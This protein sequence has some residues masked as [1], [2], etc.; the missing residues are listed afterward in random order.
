VRR[1]I[2][3][4]FHVARPK[5]AD[6]KIEERVEAARHRTSK[7]GEGF[8]A[9]EKATILVV[10][11]DVEICEHFGLILGENGFTVRCAN[12]GNAALHILD[13][14]AIDVIIS[15]ILMPNGNGLKVRDRAKALCIPIILSTGYVDPYKSHIS[16][17]V[18]VMTKPFGI[19]EL[20]D[21]IKQ[22]RKTA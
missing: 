7:T 21:T 11:D 20:L 5:S 19:Q 3:E 6:R 22:L 1:R 18:V 2:A 9:N 12:S 8:M 4:R 14:E 15:D 16:E 17:G 13:T 10:D